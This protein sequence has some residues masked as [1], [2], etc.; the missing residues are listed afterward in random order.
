MRTAAFFGLV[1]AAD[2][3]AVV[4]TRCKLGIV[5]N[6]TNSVLAALEGGGLRDLFTVITLADGV[7]LE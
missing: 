4:A 2:F 7:G 5:A 3:L 6:S 1:L